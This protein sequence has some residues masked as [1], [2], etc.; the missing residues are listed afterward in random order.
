MRIPADLGYDMITMI[1]SS[2]KGDI[3]PEDHS[4]QMIL[5]YQVLTIVLI[6]V[7]IRLEKVA[8]KN[9]ILVCCGLN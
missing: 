1:V 6:P 2:E 3:T 7:R 9:L 5:R 8:R 4:I